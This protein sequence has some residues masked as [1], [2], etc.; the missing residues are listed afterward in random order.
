MKSALIFLSVFSLLAAVLITSSALA[1]EE[2]MFTVSPGAFTAR[3]V[4]PMGYAYIIPQDLVVWN[5]DNV[6]RLASIT[7]EVPP[8]NMVTPGY[9]PIPNE[10]WVHPFFVTPDNQFVSSI[11]IPENSFALASISIDMPRWEN[12]TG[13][14]WEVWIPV[15]RQP[16]PGEIGVLRPT[17]IMKIETTEELPEEETEGTNY[18][19]FIAVGAVIAAIAAGVWIWSRRMGR[20]GP[21]R[22]AIPRSRR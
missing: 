14:K 9:E 16:M 22:R 10:N 18:L 20:R 8:E 7:V 19:V 3:D 12:L 6:E 21:E 4:P 1:Q 2:G 15:E 5:R 11:Q 17:V 13:Q